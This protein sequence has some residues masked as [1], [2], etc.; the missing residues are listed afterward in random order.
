MTHNKMK[1]EGQKLL[2]LH[3]HAIIRSH[4]KNMHWLISEYSELRHCQCHRDHDL[5]VAKSLLK[6][7][8]SD[9]SERAGGR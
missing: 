4:T 7:V 8:Q 1:I 2:R 3:T 5:C 6:Y 9:L